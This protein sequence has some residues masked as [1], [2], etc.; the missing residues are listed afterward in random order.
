ML[1]SAGVSDETITSVGLTAGTDA[2]PAPMPML[3]VAVHCD[4]PMTAPSRHVLDGIDEVR[5]ARGDARWQRD[6]R[7]LRLQIADPRMSSDHGRL[8]R[9]TAG[10]VLDDPGSKNGCIVNGHR[11]R[12]HA[13]ADGDIFELGHT[14]CFHRV[15]PP[16]TGALDTDGDR[17]ERPLLEG[18]TFVAALELELARLARIAATD[19]P[20]LVYGETGTGK[21]LVARAIHDRSARPGPFVAVNCGALPAALVEG[22]LF[23]ARKGAFSG[24]VTDRP[25]LV[26]SANGGT[27]FLDEIAELETG[28]Q[29]AFLRVLQEREVLPLG[30]TRPIKVD[31]RFCAATH[32]DL[33]D[34]VERG[35]FRRD[36]FARL[37]G[38]AITLPPLRQRREDL[39]LLVRAL[40]RHIPD[41][42]RARLSTSATRLLFRHA[43]PGNVRELEKTLARAI[44]LAGHDAITPDHLPEALRRER[45]D[46]TN[47][48]PPA[49]LDDG[50]LGSHLSALLTEHAGNIAAVARA[51]GKEP[52]Q[53]RRWVR[54]FGFD[55]DSFRRGS[56]S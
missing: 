35:K 42:A 11:T 15:A 45:A 9:T 43:W 6:G 21:E 52:M 13:L 18:G 53:I 55:L 14:V 50:E 34:M 38:H 16:T 46:A 32:Q 51:M 10:W 25:G 1:Q 30:E 54:R 56:Q 7:T 8:V 23:G 19:V 24:A 4:R 17:L 41:G 5:F 36:L 48:P 40:L 33:D 28:S 20:V 31:V 26:R 22:E 47:R 3:V 44:A 29:A 49:N 37:H 27:L 39:G 2:A 12:S